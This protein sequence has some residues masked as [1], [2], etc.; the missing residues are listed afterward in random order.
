[1]GSLINIDT[2]KREKRETLER[3]ILQKVESELKKIDVTNEWAAEERITEV[4]CV[5]CHALSI[6]NYVADY[7]AERKQ[8]TAMKRGNNREKK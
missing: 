6:P 2:Y 1:M 3:R 5:I 7:E 4:V 8:K